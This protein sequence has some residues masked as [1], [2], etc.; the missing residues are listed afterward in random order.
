MA[1]QFGLPAEARSIKLEQSPEQQYFQTNRDTMPINKNNFPPP[2][3]EI[4][5]VRFNG[6]QLSVFIPVRWDM[7]EHH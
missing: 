2:A 1:Y 4:C 7:R 3:G 5:S 6:D